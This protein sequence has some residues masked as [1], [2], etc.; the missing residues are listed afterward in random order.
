MAQ[1]IA[2]LI[3]A[4]GAGGA[5]R[6]IGQ[7]CAHWQQTGRRVTVISFDAPEDQIYHPLPDGVELVR[8]DSSGGGV[9]T[10]ARKAWR[11][12]KALAELK[13]DVLLS[14][15]T[16][17]N[18][19]AGIA[20]SGLPHRWA[21]CERNNPE[22]QGAHPLWNRLLR[23]A[24]R[25]ADAI[26]CQTK[27][28][29]RCFPIGLRDKLVVIANPV[30]PP[31]FE[32]GVGTR[33]IAGVGR[34]DPQKGFDLLV[35]A[36]AR[37]A[38]RHPDWQLDI[39]GSGNEQQALEALIAERGLEGSVRLRGTSETPGEWLSETEIFVLSSR[40]E[41]FPNVLGEAMAA[42]LPTV[43]T[44][45]DFGPEEMLHNNTSGML[46]P[47]EQVG[48]LAAAMER[49]VKD[50][51]MRKHLG[52]AARVAARDFAPDRILP[53]WDELIDRLARQKSPSQ[54]AGVSTRPAVAEG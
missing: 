11:L 35:K 46:V 7:L 6:V 10:V 33:T 36:F 12:R 18:L 22:M 26:V 49:L 38:P 20:G 13:P 9:A 48:P 14:F 8:L 34:L 2:I 44:L 29:K 23:R 54:E 4:L 30:T 37:I 42:G 1:H 32:A 53:R 31:T 43:A 3:T 15:L 52:E 41:G 19:I 25:R 28:V 47:T 16:K 40:F 24:Y 27:G 21:A 39:W 17:N 45:C 50:E 5:E 51:D